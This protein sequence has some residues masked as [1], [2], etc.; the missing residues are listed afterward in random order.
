MLATL[1]SLGACRG[2]PPSEQDAATPGASTALSPAD[3]ADT[4]VAADTTKCPMWGRW[5]E[6]SVAERLERAGLVATK[7]DEAER[8]DFMSVPGTVFETQ[9]TE[10]QVF[11]YESEEAR[12]RD[13]DALDSTTVSPRGRQI[14]WRAPAVLVTSGNL[15]AIILGLNEREVERAALALGAGLPPRPPR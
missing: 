5:R 15:A 4:T 10:I 13:T 12:A 2:E 6:C 11:L 14:I 8:H 1:L 9:R 7:R 3:S